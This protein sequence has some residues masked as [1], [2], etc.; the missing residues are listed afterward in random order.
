MWSKLLPLLDQELS[1]LPEKYR[2]PILL[3]DLEGQSRKAA[4]QR[5]GWT[6]GT[7]SGRLARACSLLARRLSARGVTLTAGAL[8]VGLVANLA[9][10]NVPGRLILYTVRAAGLLAAGSS[11]AAGVVSA[12][13]AILMQ[14]VLR[15]MVITKVKI[16]TIW[17]LAAG[18]GF[19]KVNDALGISPRVEVLGTSRSGLYQHLLIRVQEE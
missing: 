13:V 9:L 19:F 18:R 2:L 7:L 3:C 5:L 16:L 4:A 12:K 11:K 6:E 1:H 17:L 10:A 8:A 14:G 15:T